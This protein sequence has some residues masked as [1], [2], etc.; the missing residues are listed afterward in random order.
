M[1]IKYELYYTLQS[2]TVT[3]TYDDEHLPLKI[4]YKEE[5][6]NHSGIS[7]LDKVEYDT[8]LDTVGFWYHP[9]KID[10][11]QKFFKLLRKH[12]KFRYFGVA[13][14]GA[15]RARP[16]Y[17][18]IFFFDTQIDKRKFSIDVV[19]YW[20]K[21]SQIVIDDTNDD[22]IGYTLK[23]CLKPYTSTDPSPKVFM[24]KRP[25]IGYRYLTDSTKNYLRS[26]DTDVV[27]T[28]CGKSRLPR[29]LR[30]K[31]Y[32]DDMKEVHKKALED[33]RAYCERQDIKNAENIGISLSEYRQRKQDFF[34]NR[35]WKQ[36][37]KKS[38]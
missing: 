2:L 24:S 34:V 20:K 37:K 36:I 19:K 27:N 8:L 3:L 10:D 9:Y 15:K 17:H 29:L 32:D 6:L 12:Y 18:I 1:R 33:Y 22:C 28:I 4:L 23:Y 26:Q 38:L 14:Y 30:D 31:V 13:E 5:T 16:H 11:V 7:D 21:G 35:V 25:F